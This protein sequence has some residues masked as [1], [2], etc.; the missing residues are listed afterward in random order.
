VNMARKWR[1]CNTAAVGEL[2][3]ESIAGYVY[4]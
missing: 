2:F 1:R 4:I 3:I